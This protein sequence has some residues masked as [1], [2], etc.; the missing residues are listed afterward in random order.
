VAE[1]SESGAEIE[2]CVEAA[3]SGNPP[4]AG[5]A[6]VLG[7]F[8]KANGGGVGAPVIKDMDR[9][10]KKH[11]GNLKLG[12]DFCKSITEMRT[13]DTTP[14]PTSQGCLHAR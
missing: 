7:Q 12:E 4:C 2:A 8:V 9:F 6:H 10:A 1:F 5:Y 13:G 3:T 11:A 14:L